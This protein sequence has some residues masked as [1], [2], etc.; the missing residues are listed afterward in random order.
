MNEKEKRPMRDRISRKM[1]LP[2][3][4]FS[5]GIYI[6]LRG[7]TELCL[8][9]C[10]RIL[11]YSEDEM[12]FE[13]CDGSVCVRGEKLSAN[14]YLAGTVGVRGYIESVSFGGRDVALGAGK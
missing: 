12:I 7:R 10:R 3:E 13:I 2:T 11:K 9:G 5:G 6:E 1:F 14:S 8:G 4:T